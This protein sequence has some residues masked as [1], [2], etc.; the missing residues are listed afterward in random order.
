LV[1]VAI[2]VTL[3]YPCPFLYS[4]DYTGGAS[5]IPHHV[6][7]DAQALPE[8]SKIEADVIMRSIWVH[9]SYM[10]VLDREV[11]LGALELQDG[12][13][14]QTK[15]FSPRQPKDTVYPTDLTG[16][17]L[18]KDRDKFH[19]INGLTNQSWF[20]HSP[21]LYWA[22][23]GENIANDA[24]ILETVNARKS[25]PTSVNVTLRHSIVFSGKRFED[26]RLVA[27][28]AVVITL[29][30]LRDSPVGRQWERRAEALAESMSDRWQVIPSDVRNL[31]HK[32]YEFQFRPISVQ[33][34][35]LVTLAYLLTLVYF[36]SSFS[37]L[38][39]VKSRLGLFITVLIQI[40]ASTVSSLTLCA[41]FNVD[42]SRIPYFAYPL[43]VLAIS[44]ENSSRLIYAVILANPNHSVNSRIGE[45]FGETAHIALASRVQNLL[46]L[47][48]LSKITFP[49]VSA[50]C[51]FAA[52]AT[53]M[54]FFYLST[55]F[56]AVL[57]VD[58][59]RTELSDA[60]EKAAALRKRA[61]SV[62]KARKTWTDALLQGK[63]GLS[64]RIAGTIV[65][66]GSVVIAQW[67]FLEN[68]SILKMLSRFFNLSGNNLDDEP[69]SSLL[70]DI[71]QARSPTSWLRLQ[72]HE[73]A[74]EVINVVKPW[75][76]SY[77]ARVYEPLVFVLKGA[78]RIPHHKERLF[79]PALYDFIRHEVPRFVVVL[80]VVIA[81]VRLLTNYL[82]WDELAEAKQDVAKD[83]K[84]LIS[85][86]SLSGGHLLDVALLSASSDGHL[87]SAGLDRMIQ[88][89]DVK[90]A[91]KIRVISDPE[92]PM[93]NPFPV[94]SM[95]IDKSSTWLAILSTTKIL[96]WSLTENRWGP[97][98]EVDMS[99][100]KVEAFF[101]DC[102]VAGRKP[103]VITVRRNGSLIESDFETMCC[104]EHSVYDGHLVS[105]V[106]V[107]ERS[108]S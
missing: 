54:D 85:V 107:D 49:G 58:V 73:T 78:D 21:L 33:D 19:V 28:D 108:K 67:H 75:A 22:C 51:V 39:A 7:T 55:F 5:S 84:P 106:P 14:G 77:V 12:L 72:D 1:A 44:T 6:W 31:T 68:E 96:L 37:K 50:F 101:F 29:I 89:W 61:A 88:V 81:L 59:Q 3:T 48:G 11:L 94:L 25:Q 65:I 97:S 71:H 40:I 30:H 99:K 26:R 45:A 90:S 70:V 57:S 8:K 35:A 36:V 53:I 64:T 41:I 13:L 104:K 32:L 69:K 63:T 74:R 16:D 87:V 2:A 98:M 86:K 27:A 4:T 103:T 62:N 24:D 52:L 105:A 76:H 43:V 46:I 17:L 15:N 23:S 34:R 60:I 18:P 83:E 91:Q 79:L 93:E 92:R 95:T 56:L 10:Q 66:L 42:V 47:W 9:G 38:R 102:S 20:F 80:L 82:L 100:H